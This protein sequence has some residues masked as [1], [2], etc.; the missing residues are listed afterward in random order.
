MTLK[1]ATEGHSSWYHSKARMR[2]AIRF[3]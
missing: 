2:F 3:L 1:H